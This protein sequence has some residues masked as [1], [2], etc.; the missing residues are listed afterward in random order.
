MGVFQSLAV[1]VF[2]SVK[3]LLRSGKVRLAD[4]KMENLSSAFLCSV[5]ERNE[6]TDR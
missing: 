4:V 6:F 5:C 2:K 1:D 3:S